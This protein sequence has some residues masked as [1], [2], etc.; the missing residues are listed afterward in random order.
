MKNFM[1]GI[2]VFYPLINSSEAFPHALLSSGTISAKETALAPLYQEMSFIPKSPWRTLNDSEMDILYTQSTPVTPC[3]SWISIVPVPDFVL[4]PFVSLR[5]ASRTI[6]DKVELRKLVNTPVIQE[7]IARVRKFATIF[8]SPN[9]TDIEGGKVY[10]CPPSM[11]TVTMDESSTFVG[12][13]VDGWYRVSLEEKN[14]VPN[15]LAVNIGLEDRFF[16]YINLSLLQI[17]QVMERYYPDDKERHEIG[18]GLRTAFLKRFASYPVVKLRIKPGEAYIAPTENCIHDG[19]SI[20]QTIFDLQVSV[21]GA[22]MP[23]PLRP[24][25]NPSKSL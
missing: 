17:A 10:M 2:K 8:T 4:E 20:G 6:K 7:G 13:H 19:C 15:R 3:G 14:T 12:L 1:E 18:I 11:E 25:D 5:E 24:F 21:R 22:F 9:H 16:L 23:I